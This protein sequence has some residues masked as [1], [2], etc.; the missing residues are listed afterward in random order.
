MA[1]FLDHLVE[2]VLLGVIQGLT[3]WLP[4]SSTG[5]LRM[6]ENF[7]GL[8]FPVFFDVVLHFGTLIVILAFFREDVDRII[9]SLRRLDFKT[10]SGRMVPLI[11]VGVIPTMLIGLSFGWLI[12]GVFQRNLP[13]GI[14]FLFGGTLLFSSRVGKEKGRE[15][16]YSTAVMMG[17]AQ[18]VAIVPGISRSGATIA[19]A[20]LLGVKR[21]EA[22]KF[23]FLLSVPA[24]LGALS[25]TLYAQFRE[26]SLS[27]LGWFEVLAGA[28]AAMVVG[29]L[30]LRLLWKT[31]AQRKFYMFAFYC[32]LF[33]AML[34]LTSVF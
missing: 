5:H 32:W 24:I 19:V 11:I 27:G 4:V 14:A 20:L 8:E 10:E 9:F 1:T 16:S 26:F 21:E 30:A 3:E 12:E 25:Y 17:V 29:Y 33:G 7:L 15:I 22:F 18:G 31:I 6:F 34:V 13:I 23:S 2:T 28:S